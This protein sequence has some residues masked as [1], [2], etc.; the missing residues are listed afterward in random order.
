MFQVIANFFRS[1]GETWVRLGDTA[2]WERAKLRPIQ[3]NFKANFTNFNIFQIATT[4]DSSLGLIVNEEH[5]KRHSSSASFSSTDDNIMSQFGTSPSSISIHS[6]SEESS[7]EEEHWQPHCFVK[8][9][10]SKE[11][12]GCT[13]MS[14]AFH[15][16]DL[17]RAVVDVRRF[18]YVCKVGYF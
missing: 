6:E 4:S 18:N 13:S 8:T 1:P 16:L 3:V 15:R 17:A 11:F 14:E 10:K 9:S 12:I 7:A 5:L 2:N